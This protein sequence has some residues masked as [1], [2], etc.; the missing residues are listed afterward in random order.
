MSSATLLAAVEAFEDVLQ[1]VWVN[2]DP[3]I[4]HRGLLALA[5]TGGSEEQ[6]RE[7]LADPGRSGEQR[8]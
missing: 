3:A 7:G 8:R 2:P 5:C 1:V 6:R 4:V